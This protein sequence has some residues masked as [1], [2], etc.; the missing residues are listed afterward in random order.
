MLEC[1]VL[2]CH[3]DRLG[4]FWSLK[5]RKIH[6]Q[7]LKAKMQ[8]TELT[9][10]RGDISAGTSSGAARQDSF[11]LGEKSQGAKSTKN[12]LDWKSKSKQLFSFIMKCF[13]ESSSLYWSATVV[14]SMT[15]VC[16]YWWFLYQLFSFQVH[17]PEPAAPRNVSCN[18]QKNVC[19][20]Q[21][22]GPRV[23]VG[24]LEQTGFVLEQFLQLTLLCSS[25]FYQTPSSWSSLHV[26][27]YFLTWTEDA[28]GI[29]ELP[30]E[31]PPWEACSEV[32]PVQYSVS[33]TVHASLGQSYCS[34]AKKKQEQTEIT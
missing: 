27:L 10:L 29:F 23:H 17:R 20:W 19:T 28:G 31:N 11:Y 34:V 8:Q 3:S 1:C 32:V 18:L 30:G 16:R 33:F 6:H 25:L 7:S 26:A 24:L 4:T 5:S 9:R 14:A 22:A 13:P 21:G 2:T 15:K 12:Y